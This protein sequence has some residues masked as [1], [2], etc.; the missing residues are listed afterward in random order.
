VNPIEIL[1][2]QSDIAPLIPPNSPLPGRQAGGM[3]RDYPDLKNPKIVTFDPSAAATQPY[4]ITTYQP[5]LFCGESMTD[6]KEKI[7]QYCDGMD[8]PFHPV[9]DPMTQTVTV[10][11]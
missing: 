3:A 11:L 9:Y 1:F 8:R 4:P 5:I 7:T 6:V 2:R 10:G